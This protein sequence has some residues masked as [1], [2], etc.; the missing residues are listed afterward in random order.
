MHLYS[1]HVKIA[2]TYKNK[3]YGTGIVWYWYCMVLV[4]HGTA[5]DCYNRTTRAIAMY[6]QGN[7]RSGKRLCL[8]SGRSISLSFHVRNVCYEIGLV[9]VLADVKGNWTHQCESGQMASVS[10]NKSA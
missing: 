10:A 3:L 2:Y 8:A 9:N 4:L 1:L 6:T 7:A 5:A